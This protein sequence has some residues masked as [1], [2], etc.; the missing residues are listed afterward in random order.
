MYLEGIGKKV[1]GSNAICNIFGNSKLFNWKKARHNFQRWKFIT[2]Y[3]F[4][5]IQGLKDFIY[6]CTNV[7][8][9][10]KEFDSSHFFSVNYIFHKQTFY[11]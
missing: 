6:M 8:V 7:Y 11:Q 10:V 5:L 4:N 9:I 2:C 3:V 1:C